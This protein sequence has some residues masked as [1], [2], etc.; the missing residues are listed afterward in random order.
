MKE[1]RSKEMRSEE[2]RIKKMLQG[3]G[4]TSPIVD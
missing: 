2:M 3:E 4:E 1:M